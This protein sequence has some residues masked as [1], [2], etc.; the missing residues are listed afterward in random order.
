[1]F[2]FGKPKKKKE[3]KGLSI[4]NPFGF[5]PTNELF[6]SRPV[7]IATSALGWTVGI[8]AVS[9]VATMLGPWGLVFGGLAAAKTYQAVKNPK[10]KQR[11]KP[12]PK[13]QKKEQATPEI[14]PLEQ[15]HNNLYS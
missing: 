11:K 9:I 2:G 13:K 6:D 15:D 1:M 3:R 5:A 12:K 14:D 7:K 8:K 10:P 4:P